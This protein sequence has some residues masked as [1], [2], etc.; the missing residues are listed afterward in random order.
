M[1]TC[2]DPSMACTAA[3]TRFRVKGFVMA[4]KSFDAIS[5]SPDLYEVVEIEKVKVYIAGERKHFKWN[6]AAHYG[7]SP[8]G[9][10]TSNNE[11]YILGKRLGGI[12]IVNQVILGH[13]L[14]HLLN[15]K[16]PEISDPDEL[17][18]LEWCSAQRRIGGK[19]C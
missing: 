7:S 4:S 3:T 1:L 16:N 12:I 17:D 18:R 15:F 2:D 11:I 10:A 8:G 6:R 5:E 19:A 14:R 9:Y 13:E